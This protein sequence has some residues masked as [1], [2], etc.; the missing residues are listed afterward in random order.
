MNV[1]ASIYFYVIMSIL[2]LSTYS[3]NFVYYQC[4]VKKLKAILL[5]PVRF[6]LMWM[7]LLRKG[8]DK[9]HYKL[10]ISEL[11][12]NNEKCFEFAYSNPHFEW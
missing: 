8:L 2:Q 5:Q 12:E 4:K 7:H 10:S 11:Y 1:L 6:K 3:L 9:E